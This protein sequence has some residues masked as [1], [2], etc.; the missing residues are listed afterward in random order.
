MDWKRPYGYCIAAKVQGQWKIITL[1]PI[2]IYDLLSPVPLA[3][4]LDM[5]DLVKF[6]EELPIYCL[7]GS[8]K[9]HYAQ[10]KAGASS[11]RRR[12]IETHTFTLHCALRH[13]DRDAVPQRTVDK[14]TRSPALG[15]SFAKHCQAQCARA[16]KT[17][18]CNCNV[19]A[20]LEESPVHR[21]GCQLVQ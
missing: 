12:G 13:I 19:A 15:D 4:S 6:P 14:P 9:G 8:A 17:R 2:Y 5:P 3:P 1:E 21:H 11:H 10:T 7:C 18:S 16:M 20:E